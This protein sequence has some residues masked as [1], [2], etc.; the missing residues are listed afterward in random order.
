MSIKMADEN[1]DKE[2]FSREMKDHFRLVSMQTD[3]LF[4]AR[5]RTE[6]ELATE[7]TGSK[8]LACFS[9]YLSCCCC[10]HCCLTN[11]TKHDIDNRYLNN[12]KRVAREKEH[13]ITS[14]RSAVRSVSAPLPDSIP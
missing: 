12:L 13:M 14:L 4:H 9:I 8:L 5:T 3:G 1:E 7:I 10:C 6:F 2:E 11:N